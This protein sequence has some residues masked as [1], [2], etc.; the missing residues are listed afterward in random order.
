[1]SAIPHVKSV[2]AAMVRNCENVERPNSRKSTIGKRTPI[3]TTP[4]TK[5]IPDTGTL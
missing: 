4:T 5:R 1:M 3:V 2:E